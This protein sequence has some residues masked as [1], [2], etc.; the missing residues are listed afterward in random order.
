MLWDTRIAMYGLSDYARMVAD[1]VRMATYARALADAVRP[2]MV[3]ADIGAGTGVLA[4]MAAK[5]GARRV[6][7]EYIPT[8]KNG[9]VKDHY[10]RLG[11]S[12]T[13]L[14]ED[15]SSSWMLELETFEAKPT[16]IQI[17]EGTLDHRT[18]LREAH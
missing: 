10:G 6:V 14:A 9:M 2:G 5:L 12:Q 1:E 4:L 3:V 16:F 18:D 8:K 15:G 17:V 13:S 11:F 7:G